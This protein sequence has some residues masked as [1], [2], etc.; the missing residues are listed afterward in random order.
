MSSLII[1]LFHFFNRLTLKHKLSVKIHLAVCCLI[2]PCYNIK[3]SGLSGTG[4]T[5]DQKQS[6][7]FQTGK[8]N[9]L[10]FRIGPPAADS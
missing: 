8:I 3:Y 1:Y 9:L 4:R 2:N 6:P 5:R 7:S 10:F